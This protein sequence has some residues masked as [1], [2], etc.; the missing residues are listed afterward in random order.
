MKE[1]TISYVNNT[2]AVL[3]YSEINRRYLTG[4]ASSLGYLLLTSNVNYLFIDGRYYE[5]AC[6]SACNVT[7]VLLENIYEQI[8][9]VLREQNISKLLIEDNNTISFLS[10]LR[11]SIKVRV[12]PSHQLYNKL[13][14]M[15]S[16]KTKFE[17]DSII[18]AQRIA[19]KAFED[20]LEY[21]KEGVSEKEIASFLDYRMKIYGSEANAFETIVVSGKNSSLPHGVPTSKE[22]KNGDFITMDFGAKIN[23]YCSD[24][25]RTVAIGFVS[26]EMKNIYNIVLSAQEEVFKKASAGVTCSD[27][28]LVARKII[29]NAGYGDYFIHST[30]HGVGLE[31]HE[32]PFV[33]KRNFDTKLRKGQVITDEPGIYLPDKFGVRIEDMLLIT[34][35]ECKNL[36]NAPKYLIIL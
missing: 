1:K 2:T 10:N 13:S 27:L 26:E 5:A 16:I 25:T 36:T 7:V 35:N 30:G 19:E 14:V 15:R 28:D 17:I 4:F 23:G 9:D 24:M 22:I 34:K 20:V 29:E 18:A 32:L 12:V 21:I 31:I 6:K 8:N 33:S 11:K 3:I